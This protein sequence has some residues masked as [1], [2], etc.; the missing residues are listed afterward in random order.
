MMKRLS[1]RTLNTSLSPDQSIAHG[2]SY[3]AGMLLTNSTF[4]KSILNKDSAARLASFKQTS[5]NARAL[6][7]LVRDEK[8]RQRIPH[9][10]LPANTQLPAAVTQIYGT[11]IANQNQVNLRIVE[12]GT[13][14]DSSFVELGICQINGL[15]EN[16]PVDTEIEVTIKYDEEARVHVFGKV[17]VSGQVAEIKIIREENLVM[18]PLQL[19]PDFDVALKDPSPG[20]MSSDD[21]KFQSSESA[22]SF[23]GRPIKPILQ[24]ADSSPTTQQRDRL[25]NLITP[26]E[27]IEKSSQPILL[28]NNCGEPIA[29]LGDCFQCSQSQKSLSNTNTETAPDSRLKTPIRPAADKKPTSTSSQNTDDSEFW[30]NLGQ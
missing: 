10:I 8:T 12:S 30:R 27:R 29:T 22:K 1:G 9:Y 19:N 28:C 25:N 17:L 24:G 6:G 11:V 3:Y 4:A 21:G 18:R 5:V 13:A 7:I 15:P 23:A 20:S 14:A 2:A 16:L 26:K